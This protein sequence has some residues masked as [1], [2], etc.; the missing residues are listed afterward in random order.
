M[1][2]GL[3]PGMFAND[4]LGEVGGARTV[5]L[6]ANQSGLRL[7]DHSINRGQGVADKSNGGQNCASTAGG[8]TGNTGGWD[9]IDSHENLPPFLTVNFI[10]KT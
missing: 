1:P 3:D 2:F 8:Q 10:I 7:H 4:T 6:T 9:A 5:T